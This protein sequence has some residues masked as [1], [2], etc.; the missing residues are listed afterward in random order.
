W[1]WIAD[2]GSAEANA[3]EFKALYAYSPIHNAKPGVK[4]PSILITTAD[5]DDRVVPAH[6]YKYAAVMQAAQAGANP[7]LIR[8]DTK[9]AH[10]ASNT[11]K[12]IEQT[13]D[14]YAFLMENLGVS[15]K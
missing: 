13:R 5:H 14:I 7:I 6:N 4:Y 8:V 2:Y 3:A 12:A 11:T 15:Y 10:G 9:S 1:N